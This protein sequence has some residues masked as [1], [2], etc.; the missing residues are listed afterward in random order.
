LVYE[1]KDYITRWL[2]ELEHYKFII[3]VRGHFLGS[4]GEG[5]AAFYRLTDRWFAGKEPTYDF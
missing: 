5:K 4:E 1:R 2:R 3:K